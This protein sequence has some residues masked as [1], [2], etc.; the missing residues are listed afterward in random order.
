MQDKVR[1]DFNRHNKPTPSRP[2]RTM[3]RYSSA[4]GRNPRFTKPIKGKGKRRK[5]KKKLVIVST[6]QVKKWNKAA[7]NA[8]IDL[9][10]MRNHV[11][12]VKQS[13]SLINRSSLTQEV[14]PFNVTELL[15]ATDKRK[16]RNVAATSANLTQNVTTETGAQ[17]LSISL[18]RT[19]HCFNNFAIPF[20]VDLYS[21]VPKV[22]Q[23]GGPV[24]TYTAGMTDMGLVD[25][26]GPDATSIFGYPT[27]SQDFR[28]FWKIVKHK[29]VCLGPGESL[30]I[31]FKKKFKWSPS[32]TQAHSDAFQPS[33]GGHVFM[34]RLQGCYGHATSDATQLGVGA[35][36]LDWYV[37]QLVECQYDANGAK[38][39]TEEFIDTMDAE[40]SIIVGWPNNAEN[41]SGT[42]TA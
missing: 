23:G 13:T 19:A 34:V 39:V 17:S 5:H 32:S 36:S 37:D 22:D 8:K 10:L 26:T 31:N 3:P 42:N 15:N 25:G 33:I 16:I 4:R 12:T 1:S 7:V 14:I 24:A 29:R 38:Y 35:T 41:T 18:S 9:S 20:W 30:S 28:K 21:T 11:R 2:A 6:K 40:T 27:M